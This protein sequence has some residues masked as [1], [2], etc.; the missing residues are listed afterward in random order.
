M[1]VYMC[2]IFVI[3]CADTLSLHFAYFCI[4]SLQMDFYTIYIHIC[5]F[6]VYMRTYAGAICMYEKD[7]Y[8]VNEEDGYVEVALVLS[9]ASTFPISVALNTH[10]LLDPSVGAAASGECIVNV[11]IGGRHNHF[12]SP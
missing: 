11:G 4:I 3:L 9:T 7:R 10:L 2:F 5:T 12:K 1:Y 6:F 8:V